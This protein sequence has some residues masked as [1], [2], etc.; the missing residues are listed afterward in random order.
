MKKEADSA[1]ATLARALLEFRKQGGRHHDPKEL[2]RAEGQ[3][4]MTLIGLKP[5]D[6]GLR[7]S[8]LSKE[9]EISLSTLT[10]TTTSLFRLGYVAR[11]ED[12]K[13]R[14]VIRIS[15]TPRGRAEVQGYLQ[16]FGS[17]CGRIVKY[18]GRE[19]SLT[20]ARLLG[21]ISAFMEAEPRQ[22]REDLKAEERADEA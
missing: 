6:P 5:E 7:I 16:D 18:L 3:V 11:S 2:G 13:D 8:D 22:N 21:K 14:R 20:F 15:L 4:L 10:Q 17:Y 1:T 12:P 9:L 19:D